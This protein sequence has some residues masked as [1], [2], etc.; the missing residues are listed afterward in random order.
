[1]PC[2]VAVLDSDTGDSVFTEAMRYGLRV[3][4]VALPCH[5]ALRSPAALEVVG[6][7]AFGY[8]DLAYEAPDSDEV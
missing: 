3:A 6:P 4:V 7:A 8:P 1:M 5:P 2:I